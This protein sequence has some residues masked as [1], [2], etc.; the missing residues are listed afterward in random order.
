[1]APPM[2][3]SPTLT[4]AGP[5]TMA[6]SLRSV[7]NTFS[8]ASARASSATAR[9]FLACSSSRSSS[10]TRRWRSSVVWLAAITG[11]DT[12]TRATMTAAAP[13]PPIIPFFRD[14][15]SRFPRKINGPRSRRPN[16]RPVWANDPGCTAYSWRRHRASEL[17]RHPVV[18]AL[19]IV[20]HVVGNGLLIGVL[21]GV[22]HGRFQVGDGQLHAGEETGGLDVVLVEALARHGMDPFEGPQRTLGIF[23]IAQIVL[24]EHPVGTPT[25]D[26][27]PLVSTDGPIEGRRHAGATGDLQLVVEAIV[28]D[29]LLGQSR[30][31]GTGI[32]AGDGLVQPVPHRRLLE[33][34]DGTHL[35]LGH[36]G[37]HHPAEAGM[38]IEQA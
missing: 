23:Q 26:H 30:Q 11:T 33:I 16:R 28:L 32:D 7:S 29:G 2:V 22:V 8:S 5:G 19:F 9:L 20:R 3:R 13:I 25:G 10:S 35:A 1:M 15:I 27:D 14:V 6:S 18:D 38:G 24:T 4:L 34:G 31:A 17:S 21:L 36:V 37:G 12:P